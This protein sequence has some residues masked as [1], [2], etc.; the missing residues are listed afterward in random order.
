MS[1]DISKNKIQTQEKIKQAYFDPSKAGSYSGYQ[2]FLKNNKL[3]KRKDIENT[4][5]TFKTYTLHE[6]AFRK[7]P[8]RRIIVS[9]IDYVHG[10]DLADMSKFKRM[11]RNYAWILYVMD[12]FSRFVFLIPLKNKKAVTVIEALES[13]Y[14]TTHSSASFLLDRPRYC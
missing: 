2:G 11:N 4:L 9:F 8:T 5:K 12:I 1:L 14:K 6:S 10:M 13:L 3:K 7:Y